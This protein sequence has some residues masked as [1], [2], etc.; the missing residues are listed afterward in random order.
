MEL[1]TR[2]FF[3]FLS[4]NNVMNRMAKN[5]GIGIV[6]GK[7]IGGNNFNESLVYIKKLNEQGM[8]ATVDH[9]GEFVGSSE[10]ARERAEEVIHTI[11]TIARENVNAQVSLKMTSLGLDIDEKLVRENM[12]RILETAEKHQIMVTID[13]EDEAR[14]QKTLDIFKEFRLRYSNVSTVI[15]A[16]LYRSESDLDELNPLR[17]FLRLVKGAYKESP[18]VA[19][20]DKSDVDQNYKTLIRK[21]LL[22]GNYT[23]IATHD[24]HMIAYAK[25]LAK[26]NQIPASQ[27]EFQML[28]GMRNATQQTLVKEGYN[29]RVYVPYGDDWYG[30]FMRRLAERPANIVFAFKGMTKK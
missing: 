7:M 11:E 15:Q 3:L 27:F 25:Q 10:V 14:C 26:D 24:D 17:P 16:Y 1:V 30:Y 22:S 23:A 5:W 12:T 21:Q 4:K 19:F 2:D 6:R 8:T 18:K 9:L 29:V 20:P 13:M 28:Y